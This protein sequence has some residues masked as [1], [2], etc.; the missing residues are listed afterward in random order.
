MATGKLL[1][2]VE[3][4]MN[5]LGIGRTMLHRL[6]FEG[7]LDTVKI[8]RRRM[9]KVSSVHALAGEPSQ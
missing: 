8:G 5:T 3:E 6:I 2:S 7:Q 1:C 9:V 4:A